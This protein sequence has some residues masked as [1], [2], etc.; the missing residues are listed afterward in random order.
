[1]TR[2]LRTEEP[3]SRL[4]KAKCSVSGPHSYAGCWVNSGRTGV[5][6][7]T[8]SQCDLA[9]G[10]HT[11]SAMKANRGLS[12]PPGLRGGLGSKPNSIHDRYFLPFTQPKSESAIL[13][14]G[15]PQLP[16]PWCHMAI[17]NRPETT[18]GGYRG[19]GPGSEEELLRRRPRFRTP[20]LRCWNFSEGRCS[21]S[22]MQMPQNLRGRLGAGAYA[23]G[24]R[25]RGKLMQ[26]TPQRVGL[27]T[28]AR[29]LSP[30]RPTQAGCWLWPGGAGCVDLYMSRGFFFSSVQLTIT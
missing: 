6:P 16:Q 21:P 20:F 28:G 7:T 30:V 18:H 14:R 13:L 22:R 10:T 12:A 3:K 17:K 24:E 15:H 8:P 25:Q 9:L 5:S 27:E 29:E 4:S 23:H 2:A 11:D 26:G 1:M 19:W